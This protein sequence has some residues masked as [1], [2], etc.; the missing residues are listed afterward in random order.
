M[1]A[2]SPLSFGRKIADDSQDFFSD[3][4]KRWEDPLSLEGNSHASFTAS[5]ISELCS[6]LSCL[7]R[8]PVKP[9]LTAK[10][11]RGKSADSRDATYIFR[12]FTEVRS[13]CSTSPI[14]TTFSV[15]ALMS[16]SNFVSS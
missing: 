11:S 15:V 8:M 13:S 12:T 16:C 2:A 6:A 3:P 4:V 5:I 10:A 9:V 14:S 7:D 1:A